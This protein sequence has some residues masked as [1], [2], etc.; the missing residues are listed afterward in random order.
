[1]RGTG[2]RISKAEV[3]SEEEFRVAEAEIE[4]DVGQCGWWSDKPEGDL[5]TETGE[6]ETGKRQRRKPPTRTDGDWR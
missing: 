5:W 3:T 6:K 1:M 2:E 4:R